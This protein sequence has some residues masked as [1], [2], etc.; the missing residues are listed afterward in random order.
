MK[1]C[2]CCGEN[3]AIWVKHYVDGPYYLCGEH[4][5]VMQDSHNWVKEWIK[6]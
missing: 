4:I 6:I 2:D 3:K 5:S 1:M